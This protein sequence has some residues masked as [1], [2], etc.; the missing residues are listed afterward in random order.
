[1]DLAHHAAA[2]NSRRGAAFGVAGIARLAA[3]GGGGAGGALA[4]HLGTLVPKLYR[5]KT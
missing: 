4:K 1:M 5:C 3:K 2:L